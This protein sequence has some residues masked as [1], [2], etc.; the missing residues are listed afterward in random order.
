MLKQLLFPQWRE[1]NYTTEFSLHF[2][3][4][5]NAEYSSV[6]NY[7]QFVVLTFVRRHVKHYKRRL[8]VTWAWL[9]ITYLLNNRAFLKFDEQL[10]H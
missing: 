4:K 5:T 8:M 2:S 3:I 9:K 6:L 10:S 7:F 1:N